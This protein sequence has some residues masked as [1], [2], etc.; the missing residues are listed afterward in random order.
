MTFLRNTFFIF[1]IITLFGAC[2]QK[3]TEISGTI[4][5]A[6]NMT[7]YL[8]NV[9]L[10]K[11][12]NI[13]LQEKISPDGKFTMKL[14][15]GIKKGSYRLRIGEQMADLIMDGSEK[16]IEIKGKLSDFNEFLHQVTGSKLTE[17]YNKKVR[18]YIEQ[19]MDVPAL[20]TYTEKTADPLVAYQIATR[21]FM[22]RP[23]FI[24]LHKAVS[25]R[26]SASDPQLELAKEYAMVIGQIEQQAMME[27]AAAKIKVGEPAPE[28]ALPGPD[29][30]IRK[31]SDYKGKLVLLDFW[32]SWCGPCRK[33]N[34]HVV[35][36]YHKYKKQGFDVFSV[37]L[38]GVDGR[39]AQSMTDPAQLK[40]ATAATKERWI[41]AISQDQL[42]WDGHVSDL[43]KWQSA[44]A[45]VY[46]V[47]SIPSTFLV[48]RDGK[49]VAVN[50]R[51]NL[52]EEI[53]KYL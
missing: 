38:D 44:P 7:A 19:K 53:K 26:L 40:E 18:E 27:A 41:S 35:E 5:G 12:S 37:S 29:G 45:G 42:V 25:A 1:S 23:E 31:L 3:A 6:E 15:E 11:E 43:K 48:G 9:M 21:L 36:I 49:I 22:L 47:N 2:K 39:T 17:E 4:G 51:T 13:L 8:D 28:I 10:T 16:D 34:P 30:K 24:N 33:A 46:G 20:T 32:A 52:E 50:P 14:P